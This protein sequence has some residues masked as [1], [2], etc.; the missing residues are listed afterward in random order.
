MSTLSEQ[1]LSGGEIPYD[2]SDFN[3]IR[4]ILKEKSGISLSSSK[5][6]LVYSRLSRRVRL[7]SLPDFRSYISFVNSS[8][9]VEERSCMIDALT[10]NV[11]NF[12]REKYHFEHF[13]QVVMPEIINRAQKGEKI[14]IWSSA[15][16]S[17]QEPFS[18][19]M[20]VLDC[21]PTANKYDIKILATD[22]SHEM[23]DFCRRGVY[24]ISETESIA[25]DFL[26]KYSIKTGDRIH[27]SDD[28]KKLI[29]F[30]NLNLLESWPMQ[31]QFTSIFCRNV[32][33]Y[34]DRATQNILWRRLADALLPS[35][36]LYIGHSEKIA[37]ETAPDI[38]PCGCPTTYRKDI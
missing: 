31:C 29:S 21:F 37:M 25:E 35:G 33:I 20:T 2:E 32:A 30:R 3:S 9:G 13:A 14:R 26:K 38:T 11:T 27:F 22:I 23:I 36:Y 34:F 15:C 5:M 17:G 16:S 1:N 24:S 8:S 4:N 12:F 7:C 18:I 6:R 10:T 19:A 28:I